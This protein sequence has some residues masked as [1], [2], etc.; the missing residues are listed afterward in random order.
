MKQSNFHFLKDIDKQL[1]QI[2][3]AAERNYPGDPNTTMAKLRIFGEAIAKKLALALKIE[4]TETQLV[5]IRER[6][7]VPGISD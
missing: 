3:L 1:Y 7:R 6:A 4:R 5:I 2:A